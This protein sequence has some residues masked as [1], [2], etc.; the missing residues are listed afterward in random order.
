MPNDEPIT[1]THRTPDWR[2]ATDGILTVGELVRWL[3]TL[4]PETQVV[5]GDTDGWYN[6][7]E[8]LHLPDPDGDTYTAVTLVQGTPYDTRQA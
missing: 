6:N 5:V 8:G 2:S 7:L 1:D 4:P 3:K